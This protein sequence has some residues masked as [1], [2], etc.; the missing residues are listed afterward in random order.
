MTPAREAVTIVDAE[1]I[2]E[3]FENAWRG[4]NAPALEPFIAALL[5]Q[6]GADPQSLLRDL[7]TIDLEYRYRLPEGSAPVAGLPVRPQLEDYLRR[8]PVLVTSGTVRPELI[9]AEYKVRC[10]AGESPTHDEYLRRFGAGGDALSTELTRIDTELAAEGARKS[11]FV[12]PA[13]PPAAPTAAVTPQS[14]LEAMRQ[15]GL[16]H[17]RQLDELAGDVSRFPDAHAFAQHLLGRDLITPFQANLLLRGRAEQLLVGPYVLLARLG[18]GAM[19]KVYKAR[20]H[21]L[22]RVAALKVFRKGLLE[23]RGPEGLARI[24]QEV[25]AAGRLSDPHVIH[26]YD[27]GPAGTAHFLAMEYHESIDLARY[28]MQSGPLPVEQACD[29]IRQAALGL[30][31]AHERGLVHRDIKPSNLLVALPAMWKSGPPQG[32]SPWGLVKILDLGLARLS[33]TLRSSKNLTLE[34]HVMGT[35]DYMAPEQAEDPH[36]ADIRADLY[37]LGCTLYFML[38]GQPPF[39]GGNFLEK[40]NRHRTEMPP[41]VDRLR[42]D[43][44]AEVAGVLR[45][46]LAKAPEQRFQRPAEVAEALAV[47]GRA[48]A[49]PAEI[50]G[51]LETYVGGSTIEKPAVAALSHPAGPPQRRRLRYIIAGGAV[52]ALFLIGFLSV[53]HFAGKMPERGPEPTPAPA[54]A[55]AATVTNSIGMRLTLIPAGK[56]MMGSPDTEVGRHPDE[57]PQHPVTISRP[58]YMGIHEVTQ[59]QYE[60][61]IGTNPSHFT[62]AN[63]G[64]ANHPVECV[65]WHDAVAFCKKLSALPAERRAGR[66]YRLPTEAEWEYANRA[67]TSTPYFYNATQMDRFAWHAANAAGK[68]REVGQRQPNPWGLYDISGNVWEWCADFKGDYSNDAPSVDPKG[69]QT[70]TL[71]VFRGGCVQSQPEFLRAAH[72]ELWG[73]PPT[74]GQNNIG[75]R[76]VCDV[77]GGR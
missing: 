8:H 22:G 49:T 75:F 31:H 51:D 62:A 69:P 53:A 55:P 25:E 39:V 1:Q 72:R 7:I 76:V 3:D 54:P 37:S 46:L 48:P 14:M 65:S 18:E 23:E 57:G 50:F 12:R 67:G 26:A 10:W 36:R 15:Y 42:P 30:Q 29:Y 2:L 17:Q 40:V 59:E 5:S 68:T 77:P 64:G 32:A 52:L 45:R 61:V 13:E 11:R 35:P 47:A 19:G 27:A 16:L 41:A 74:R 28:V 70:G 43:V 58:F 38:T 66:V 56:F 9:A 21:F 20:H 33:Q 44:S 24:Y 34:G 73:V 60:G 6:R 4:G 71:R 63:G